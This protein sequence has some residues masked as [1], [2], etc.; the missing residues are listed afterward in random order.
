MD[1]YITR[2]TV[3]QEEMNEVREEERK[4]SLYEEIKSKIKRVKFSS[5]DIKSLE[6]FSNMLDKFI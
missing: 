2:R 6:D 4:N 1:G 5:M 3:T